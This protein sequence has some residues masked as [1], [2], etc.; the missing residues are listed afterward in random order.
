MLTQSRDFSVS[1]ML[2]LY[3]RL[4][5]SFFSL[6]VA[7]FNIDVSVAGADTAAVKHWRLD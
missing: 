3:I 2:K 6:Y 1:F 4:Q 5:G 7:V